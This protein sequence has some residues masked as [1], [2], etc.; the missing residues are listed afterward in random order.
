MSHHRYFPDD[1]PD[2][3]GEVSYCCSHALPAK[4]K[5]ATEK[6]KRAADLYLSVMAS[7]DHNTVVPSMKRFSARDVKERSDG[8]ITLLAGHGE[9]PKGLGMYPL[10]SCAGIKFLDVTQEQWEAHTGLSLAKDYPYHGHNKASGRVIKMSTCTSLAT[11]EETTASA[12]A[13]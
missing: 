12:Y 5:D 6:A 10:G 4:A 2:S 11:A 9:L 8:A 1:T 13:G 3:H 7:Q